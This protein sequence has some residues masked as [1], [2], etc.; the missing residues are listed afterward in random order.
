MSQDPR[1][2]FEKILALE[3]L[4]VAVAERM[5]ELEGDEKALK[6]VN[7][8]IERAFNP[9]CWWDRRNQIGLLTL[10]IKPTESTWFFRVAERLHSLVHRH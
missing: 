6:A 1:Q 9:T 2:L 10:A 5:A 3:D 8:L 4:E 7:K